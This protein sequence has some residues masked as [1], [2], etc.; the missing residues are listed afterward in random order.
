VAYLA[1]L[2]ADLIAGASQWLWRHAFIMLAKSIA[3]WT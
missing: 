2:A 1:G 3:L